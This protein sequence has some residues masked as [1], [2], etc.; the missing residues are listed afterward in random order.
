MQ[1]VEVISPI[2][3]MHGML[4]LQLFHHLILI[5]MKETLVRQPHWVHSVHEL[6]LLHLGESCVIS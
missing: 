4:T 3:T 6:Y 2:A 5:V 1:S